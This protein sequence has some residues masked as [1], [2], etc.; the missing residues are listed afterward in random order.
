[1]AVLEKIRVKFGLAISIIIALALLSFIIDPGT[2]ESALHSMSSKYDVGSIAGKSIAY[3]DFL[4]DIERYN[5]INEVVT[6]SSVQNEQSQQQVRDAAWQELVDRY[7]FVKNAKAAGIAVGEAEMVDLTTGDNPSPVI[8]GNYA[9]LGDNGSFSPD[10]VVEFVQA[11]PGDESG[12]LRTYWNYLQNTVYT[13]QFYAKYGALFTAATYQNALEKELNIAGNNTTANVDY[14]Q[15]MHPFAQD[16]TIAVSASE[17]KKYYKEHQD[18]YEQK[19]GRDIEYVVFEVKPSAE[20]ISF[21]ND[22]FAEAYSQFADADNL[23]SF[24]LK[25]SDRQLDNHWYKAGEL[26]SINSEINNFVF[27][28]KGSVSPVISSGDTFY[29][30]RVLDTKPVSDSVYVK[31][32]LLQGADAKTKADSLAGVIRKGGSFSSLVAEFSADQNSAADGELGNIGWM[33]QTYIIPGFESVITAPVG[34][35]Q[36]IRTQ[37]GTHVVVVTKKTAPVV[38]KQVAILEKTA[39]AGKETT[40]NVYAQANRFSTIAGHSSAGY[41]AA[42]DSLGVYSH[43]QSITEATSSY[44]SIDQAKELTRWAFDSKAGKVSNIIT[45]NNKYF[46][47]AKVNDV[48]KEGFKPLNEVSEGIRSQLYSEKLAKKCKEE[49]AAKIAGLNTIQEVADALG[50]S[51]TSEASLSLAPMGSR[52]V[53]PALIGAVSVAEDGKLCGPVAGSFSTY[54]FVVNSREKGSFYTEDDADMFAQRAAQ[55]ASQLIIP[56]MSANGVVKD[57]RARF[58]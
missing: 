44:G 9:F 52:S 39:V 47:V 26:N 2:L 8:A 42:V 37:Y 38:K 27:E 18:F 43:K 7:M 45:V 48:H 34:Q 13:Q 17:I 32:I 1:M 15:V 30:V 53:D 6:G 41:D 33:T 46:F 25:N 22:Q 21:T 54:V 11:V 40:N 20:D 10:K 49:I 24:L 28:G 3:T 29:A 35:P 16:S 50:E 14:V 5:V 55:Y 56:S 51:V 58:F 19:A 23:K 12:R 57:N 36:V 4:E 31:H